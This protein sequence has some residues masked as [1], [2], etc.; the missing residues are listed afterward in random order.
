MSSDP[1]NPEGSYRLL[2][3]RMLSRAAGAPLL[4]G[5]AAELLIDAPAHYQA[6]LEAIRG[7]QQ[8]ILLENYLIRADEVGCTFRDALVERAQAGVLVAVVVDWL[9]CFGQSGQSFWAVACGR[10]SGKGIQ[11]S[12]TR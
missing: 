4:N 8:R 3:E 6:W 10:R 5:N 9:G 12:A 2:A 7:A 11:P 1:R